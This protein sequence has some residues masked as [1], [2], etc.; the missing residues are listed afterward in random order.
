[1]SCGSSSEQMSDEEIEQLA[2]EKFQTLT[3]TLQKQ[4]YLEC[5]SMYSRYRQAMVDSLIFDFL[6]SED[7]T[8]NSNTNSI[9]TPNQ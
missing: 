2:Q 1:M 9:K 5:D 3:D 8:A 7:S 6:K 4:Y